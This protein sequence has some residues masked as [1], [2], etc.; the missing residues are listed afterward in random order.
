MTTTETPYDVVG[1]IIAYEG[2]EL[3]EEDTVELFQYLVDTGMAW[4]LQGHYGRQATALIDY[5][6]VT[7]P[8]AS[9]SDDS[10]LDAYAGDAFGRG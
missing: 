7:R 2:D 9:A 8:D 5:G 4:S 3:D 10:D 1:A 6:Y